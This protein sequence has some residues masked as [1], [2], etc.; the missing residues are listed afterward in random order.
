MSLLIG[1]DTYV[2]KYDKWYIMILDEDPEILFS[3]TW[4]QVSKEAKE[5][6]NTDLGSEPA[7]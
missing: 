7:Q 4:D 3:G 5:G 6:W 2:I 1:P